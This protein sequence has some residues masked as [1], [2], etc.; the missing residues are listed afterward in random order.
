MNE[1]PKKK[2]DEVRDSLP[3]S[4]RAIFDRLVE[5]YKFHSLS[6]Y[7]RAFV[8]YAILGELVKEGWIPSD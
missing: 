8:S 2:K 3:V 1:L 7:G 5:E 6:L 4:K